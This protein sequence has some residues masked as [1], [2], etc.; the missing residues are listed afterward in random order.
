VKRSSTSGGSPRTNRGN[1]DHRRS[2]SGDEV[3]I[4][5]IQYVQN[6]TG[7]YYGDV[8]IENL[9]RSYSITETVKLLNDRYNNSYSSKVSGHTI[10]E[11]E[12]LKEK[13]KKTNGSG[14]K[15][16]NTSKSS[17][18]ETQQKSQKETGQTQQTTHKETST[19]H[20]DTSNTQ[21]NNQQ[22]TH[23]ETGQ[24]QQT[25]HKETGHTQQTTHKETSHSQTGHTRED[26]SVTV[27]DFRVFERTLTEKQLQLTNQTNMINKLLEEYSN[28]KESKSKYIEELKSE[29]EKFEIKK[30]KLTEDINNIN[31]HTKD[32]DDQISTSEKEL[33]NQL[34]VLQKKAE[35]FQ[36]RLH[37]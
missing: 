37:Q 30:Q 34:K 28:I 13:T 25:T 36:T 7:N 6:Q 12:E 2:E 8:E 17:N 23:K 32:L 35:P 9:L 20:K 33:V 26:D 3:N 1:R 11:K 19:T 31:K 10:D 27:D 4:K 15:K 5:D 14:S 21:Q 16:Q 24:T 29:R 22:N 18:K